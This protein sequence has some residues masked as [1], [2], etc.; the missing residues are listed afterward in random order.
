MRPAWIK[1][2]H[3]LKNKRADVKISP[4]LRS[5]SDEKIKKDLTDKVCKWIDKITIQDFKTPDF[6]FEDKLEKLLEQFDD[7]WKCCTKVPLLIR[8]TKACFHNFQLCISLDDWI[9]LFISSIFKIVHSLGDVY[10]LEN[11]SFLKFKHSV[12][13][14][15][16][17]VFDPT[18]VLVSSLYPSISES[19]NLNNFYIFYDYLERKSKQEWWIWVFMDRAKIMVADHGS[20]SR[21]EMILFRFSNLVCDN[22]FKVFNTAIES[23]PLLS[24]EFE[25]FSMWKPFMDFSKI[26]N[27]YNEFKAITDNYTGE[28]LKNDVKPLELTEW[29]AKIFKKWSKRM[30]K[31]TSSFLIMKFLKESLGSTLFDSIMFATTK[32]S[33]K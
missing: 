17:R 31:K 13:L 9:W 25:K 24:T 14:T 28:L 29:Q 10:W 2:M 19:L 5:W 1:K 27:L 11:E 16:D 32:K 15:L 4:V 21:Q 12:Y 33:I 26:Y 22:I 6:Y 3:S 18:Y 30:S 20:S 7:L 8:P 23:T